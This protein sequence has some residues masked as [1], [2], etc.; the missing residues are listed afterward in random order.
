[1]PLIGGYR[2][3][4]WASILTGL[5]SNRACVG[6]AWPTNYSPST[7]PT[8]LLELRRTLLDEWCTIPQDQIDNLVLSMPRRCRES[9]ADDEP[10]E[11]YQTSHTAENIEKVSAGACK[12]GLQTTMRVETE[13][14]VL[15]HPPYSPDFTPNDFRIFLELAFRFQG[16]RF[17]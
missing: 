13:T 1:M 3:Y 12:N 2:P 17:Q 8:C 14:I 5:E 7:P 15:P 11:S 9:A 6:Y 16:R 4:G 10:S